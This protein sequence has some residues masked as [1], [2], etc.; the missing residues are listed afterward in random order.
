MSNFIVDQIFGISEGD[1]STVAPPSERSMV[2]MLPKELQNTFIENAHMYK[3]KITNEKFGFALDF[4]M[5]LHAWQVLSSGCKYIPVDSTLLLNKT[6]SLS[7]V[8]FIEG[9]QFVWV[10]NPANDTGV[11]LDATIFK[12]KIVNVAGNFSVVLEEHI[13]I[14]ATI[15]TQYQN[16]AQAVKDMFI[17][18]A[19]EVL[20]CITKI[21]YNEHDGWSDTVV[22]L[23]Q[24]AFYALVDLRSGSQTS[25]LRI[26][27]G[28]VTI[29]TPTDQ[30]GP[31]SPGAYSAI[32]I[33][34]PYSNN[35]TD[36][37]YHRRVYGRYIATVYH[38][39]QTQYTA[40]V[41]PSTLTA[42]AGNVYSLF[43]GTYTA[44]APVTEAD[45]PLRVEATQVISPQGG[46]IPGFLK[47]HNWFNTAPGLTG[48]VTH[49]Y[50]LS[51]V[52]LANV[53]AHSNVAVMVVPPMVTEAKSTY[54]TNWKPVQ[55]LT[56]M[57]VGLEGASALRAVSFFREPADINPVTSFLV[58]GGS[59]SNTTLTAPRYN[60]NTDSALPG[61]TSNMYG[62]PTKA[63]PVFTMLDLTDKTIISPADASRYTTF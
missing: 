61:I 31:I 52:A 50:F 40:E 18:T 7:F 15:D 26:T 54:P 8:R 57:F 9:S 11:A 1:G 3:D 33:E 62:F 42:T 27:S 60:F 47:V 13:D 39:N 35:T 59:G 32:D 38:G 17:G 22:A 12:L 24:E 43:T 2:N 58:I 21:V 45:S 41:D 6:N 53:A 36:Y 16:S 56:S 5:N 4:N 28:S 48:V 20:G 44:V 63:A 46:L 29:E 51:T 49:P 19:P 55:V 34:V 23:P 25:I 10:G 37:P 14:G 30:D